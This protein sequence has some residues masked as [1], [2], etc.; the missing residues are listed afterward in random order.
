MSNDVDDVI[1]KIKKETD[2]FSKAR[3][4]SHLLK[5]KN[6]RVIDLA[7]KLNI[8]PSYVCHINRLNKLPDIIIDAY[9]SKLVTVS[10]L[11]L[12]SRITDFKKTVEIYDQILSG[13]LSVKQTE[14][15]IREHLYGIKNKGGYLKDKDR[16]KIEEGIAKKYP[17]VSAK[18][19]QTRMYGKLKLEIKGSMDTSSKLLK[20][21]GSMLSE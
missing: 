5:T 17:G 8:N 19:I 4:I 12:L 15:R 10:H 14:E 7:K 2:V 1:E 21:I 13:S 20:E 6:V 9:Y 3:L 11:F 18:I 16:E